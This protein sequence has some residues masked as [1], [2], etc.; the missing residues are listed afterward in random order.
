MEVHFTPDQEAQ[1]AD[2]ASR[3]GI[4]AEHVVKE[5]VLRLLEQE[6][7]FHPGLELPVLHL[8]VMKS[9]RRGDMYDDL[10]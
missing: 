2:L 10:R 3:A 4:D 9:L 1:L 8:G 5:T 6:T 7:H